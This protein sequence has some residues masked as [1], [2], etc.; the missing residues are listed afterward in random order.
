M[1]FL[2]K[3]G[4]AFIEEVPIEGNDC[5]EA[6]V[7]ASEQIEAE[8]P[9][10]GV[11]DSLIDDIYASN[12]LSDTTQS[13]FKVEEL[14]NSLPNEMPTDTKR[15]SVLAILRNF[16]LTI[17]EVS[18]DGD[19]RLGILESVKEKINTESASWMSDKK[20]L[21]EDCKR[22]VADLQAQIMQEEHDIKASNE[23]I[24][25]EESRIRELIDFV[26]KEEV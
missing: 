15:T 8:V 3:I 10:K 20:E 16:G 5:D 6:D 9:A 7:Y 2:E 21:I 23:L 11:I 17:T 12:D 13:I 1:G 14:I 26:G 18:S 24:A 4:K 19:K 25:K 22:T